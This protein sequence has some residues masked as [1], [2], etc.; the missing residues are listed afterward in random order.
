[1]PVKVVIPT[2]LAHY[3]GG[4]DEIEL[5]GA[6]VGEVLAKLGESFPELQP[7]IFT[8]DGTVRNFVNVFLNDENI[9]DLDNQ[10]SSVSDGDEI[11]LVPAVA[12]GL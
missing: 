10:D 2:A 8:D 11:S 9:R 12:G 7:H 4:R 6:S 1:M 3:T 5:A